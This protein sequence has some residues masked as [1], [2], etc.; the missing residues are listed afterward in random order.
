MGARIRTIK[1]DFWDD[2]K[3]ASVSRPARLTFLGLISAMSDDEGRCRGNPRVVR[4]AAYP[5]DDDVSADEI[6]S[7]LEELRKQRLIVR[8]AINGQQ[9]IQVVNFTRHQRIQKPS[10][11]QIP[12]MCSTDAIVVSDESRSTMGTIAEGCGNPPPVV[13]GNGMERSVKT[14][15]PQTAAEVQVSNTALKTNYATFPKSACDALYNTWLATGHTV[16]YARFRKALLALYT[17]AGPRYTETEMKAA[18]IA[19]NEA[20]DGVSADKSQFW[21]VNKFV[22]DIGRWVRL[23]GMPLSD[24]DGLT[25]RG[26]AALGAA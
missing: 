11:S 3:V 22:E 17:S 5:L 4:A 15:P 7:H 26:R 14:P 20:A 9:Y 19:F 6:D 23:G 21:H 8:Y 1:P 18:I 24:A 2:D 16:G 12:S 10:P 25:E 13:E